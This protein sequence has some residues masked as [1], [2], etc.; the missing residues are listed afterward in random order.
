MGRKTE[1]F[2]KY[3]HAKFSFGN[4]GIFRIMTQSQIAVRIPH[5]SD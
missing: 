3:R 5:H 2:T 1:E 4:I